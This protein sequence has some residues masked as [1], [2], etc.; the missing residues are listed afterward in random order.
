[1]TDNIEKTINEVYYRVNLTHGQ[2][3]VH[4]SRY[5]TEEGPYKDCNDL[6]TADFYS[7]NIL[8]QNASEMELKMGSKPK[9]VPREF[10]GISQSIDTVKIMPT[11]KW[12][13][14]TYPEKFV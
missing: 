6:V 10:L 11:M 12:L 8:R 1:M 3:T 4:L 2:V 14:E 9:R 5:P 13:Q 7:L